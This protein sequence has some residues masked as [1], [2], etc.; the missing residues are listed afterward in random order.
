MED[1]LSSHLGDFFQSISDKTVAITAKVFGGHP[2]QDIDL[3]DFVATID[4]KYNTSRGSGDAVGL[5]NL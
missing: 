4:S 1:A 2:S 3:T 5:M